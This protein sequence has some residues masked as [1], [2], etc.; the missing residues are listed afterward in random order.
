MRYL[1]GLM[2]V[3]A[4]GVG[5]E[6]TGGGGNGGVGGDGGTGGAAGSGGNGVTDCTGVEDG[7]ECLISNP[8]FPLPGL[9]LSGSCVPDCEVLE[10]G[11]ACRLFNETG[12]C[13]DDSCEPRC[14]NDADCT[15]YKDC[16]ADTCLSN[17]LCESVAVQDGTLCAGGTCQTGEC[18]LESTVLPCTEQ[19]IRNAIAAGGDTPYTFDCG[20]PTTVT[21]A[22]AI[23]IDNDVILDGEGQLSVDGDGEDGDHNVFLVTEGTTAELRGFTVTNAAHLGG[24]ILNRGNLTVENSTVSGN[25][26][27]GIRTEGTEG[28]LILA[29]STVSENTGDGNGAIHNDF[30]AT[31]TITNCTVS[32][33]LGMGL[34]NDEATLSVSNTTV[35]ENT[36]G[37]LQNHQGTV[38]V[39][40]SLIDGDCGG[41]AAVT[42]LG[43]NIESPGDTCGF[44]PDGTDWVDVPDPMLGPLQNNG[45]LTMTHALG[46]GSVAIDHIPAVDCGVTT[47]QRGQPRPETGGTM[48]DVGSFEVQPAP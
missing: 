7:T 4:L 42:S 16:T 17:G 30:F 33:N 23:L 38:T 31:A 22:A 37:G 2:C 10:E 1:F 19:G 5:C 3:L 47:D 13:V 39:A 44:D 29:N 41:T 21:T 34:Y 35:S 8:I 15:D 45:G 14:D 9:C 18:V 12:V 20:G 6:T 36:G 24:G 40:N 28:T 25:I 11:S 48:C 32:S 27:G 43:Y 46:G 26:G